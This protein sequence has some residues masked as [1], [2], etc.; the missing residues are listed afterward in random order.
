VSGIIRRRTKDWG[1]APAGYPVTALEHGAY[2]SLGTNWFLGSY[3][4]G[5]TNGT[6]SATADYDDTHGSGAD[7]EDGVIVTGATGTISVKVIASQDG[8]LDA[9]A[10][11]QRNLDWDDA[12]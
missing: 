6:H 1:D 9:W 3:R 12:G 10:D 8:Y 7:D 5:E 2:H 11:F 4:D